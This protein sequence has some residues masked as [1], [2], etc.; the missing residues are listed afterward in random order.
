[1]PNSR[2]SQTGVMGSKSAGSHVSTQTASPFTG[3]RETLS[4]CVDMTYTETD[5]K[6]GLESIR[7]KCV[8]EIQP[9]WKWCK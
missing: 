7:N 6:I 3:I 5:R 2:R 1:M 8:M 4:L 9:P